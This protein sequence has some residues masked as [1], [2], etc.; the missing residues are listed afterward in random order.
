MFHEHKIVMRPQPTSQ[1]RFR[2]TQ[3][4]YFQVNCL[5]VVDPLNVLKCPRFATSRFFLVV[6]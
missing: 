2:G 3:L 4:M 5:G 6:T 1:V